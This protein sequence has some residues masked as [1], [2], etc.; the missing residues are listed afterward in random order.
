MLLEI[1][2]RADDRISL[3]A[4]KRYGDHVGGHEVGYPHTE[5]ETLRDYVDQAAFGDE[6]RAFGL[7]A[8]RGI[9]LLGVQGCGKSLCAK[10]IAKEWGLPLIRLD[11]SRLYNKFFGES[12]KNLR[13]ATDTASALDR[14]S[15]RLNSSHRT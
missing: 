2:W 7:P 14:K 1:A 4:S 6:A 15:T 3:G 12:E 10:A 5:I 9:L 13:R 11:P 8:P